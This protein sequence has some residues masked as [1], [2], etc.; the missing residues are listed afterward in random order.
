MKNLFYKLYKKL[1]DIPLISTIAYYVHGVLIPKLTGKNKSCKYNSKSMQFTS[2]IYNE[3]KYYKYIK[4]A[5]ICDEMTYKSFKDEC[6]AV[7]LTPSNWLEVMNDFKPDIF[8]CESAWN[9]IEE[10]KDCWRGKIYKSKNI[11]FNNRKDIFNILDYCKRSKIKT[12]FWNK[13]DPIF[14]D[15]PKYN[16]SDTAMYFDYIFTTSSEC[17]PKYKA[18]GHKNVY[19]LMFGFSEKIFHPVN[20][21]NKKNVVIFAGSWY[22]DL[23]ERCKDMLE[24]FKMVQDNN[25]QL[26]IYDRNYNTSNPLKVFP[27]EFSSIIYKNMPFEDLKNVYKEANF[28]I[29][30]NTIKDSETMFARRV[31]ELMACNTCV[32]S[33]DSVG[34]KKMFNKNVWFLGEDFEL[35]SIKEI[36]AENV[37]YVMENHTNRQRI[38]QIYDDIGIKYTDDNK[39]L[40][41]IY[42]NFDFEKCNEHFK[43]LT[44]EDKKSFM[45]KSNQVI[46]IENEK[47]IMDINYFREN[48]KTDYFIIFKSPDKLDFDINKAIVHFSYLDGFVGICGSS[49]KF[50]LEKSNDYYNCVFNGYYLKEVISNSNEKFE[51][52]TI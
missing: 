23:S 13:E 44:Y 14:F 30:I 33:N 20:S 4:I 5:F 51:K 18:L 12:V 3:A 9:G 27:Q 1:D 16:F 46:N 2:R 52:Y 6:N 47:D 10:Y 26:K 25:I 45:I 34:M 41:I 39:N 21:N 17:V 29:N 32:I 31:F 35:D 43:S 19:T 22:A 11:F 38:K 49:N 37:Q 48:Y 24:V 28:T 7:F 8:F 36:C 15:N 42:D 50:I 40:T